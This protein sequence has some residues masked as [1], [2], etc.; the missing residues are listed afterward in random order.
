M[1][2]ESLGALSLVKLTFFIQCCC[3]PAHITICSAK[4]LMFH[5][6]KVFAAE[7][8]TVQV[9]T[10]IQMVMKTN[11]AIVNWSNNIVFDG[12]QTRYF[13]HKTKLVRFQKASYA[14]VFSL[15]ST[16]RATKLKLK[17][18][19]TTFTK[20]ASLQINCNMKEMSLRP[21]EKE[22]VMQQKSDI[23]FSGV[24]RGGGLEAAGP[25]RL[26]QGAELR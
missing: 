12:S 26:F 8:V 17:L 15:G 3:E 2:R 6:C 10:K 21:Y 4:T 16:F 19:A 5:R 24:A 13:F 23:L 9:P 22:S 11:N 1:A 14:G 18:T 25:A 7:L 20:I